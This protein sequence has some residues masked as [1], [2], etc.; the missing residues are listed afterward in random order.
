[1][2]SSYKLLVLD[3][4]VANSERVATQQIP[5]K[6]WSIVKQLVGLVS[7][8]LAIIFVGGLIF[9][10]LFTNVIPMFFAYIFVV[11]IYMGVGCFHIMA[12]TIIVRNAKLRNYFAEQGEISNEARYPTQVAAVIVIL[13][14]YV[15]FFPALLALFYNY[16]QYL[17]FGVDYYDAMTNEFRSR[18][19][20]FFG[21]VRLITQAE[22]IHT[23]LSFFWLFEI[24]REVL[25]QERDG[26]SLIIRSISKSQY[27][28]L[29][30]VRMNK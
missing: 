7:T 26:T 5:E 9:P 20:N 3:R 12:T 30:S 11:C 28:P 27:F 23:A 25:K 16:S 13:S 4:P 21:S 8:L 17:Y 6:R 14:F 2:K 10:Y 1:M 18:D 29:M 15:G 19:M 22:W 24:E